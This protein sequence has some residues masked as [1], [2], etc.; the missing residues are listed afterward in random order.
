MFPFLFFACWSF[1]WY[2]QWL[3]KIMTGFNAVWSNHQTPQLQ[4][5]AERHVSELSFS[6][7]QLFCHTDCEILHQLIFV[8]ISQHFQHIFFCCKFKLGREWKT[9]ISMKYFNVFQ[10]SISIFCFI[11][12][13]LSLNQ[14]SMTDGWCKWYGCF[15][16]FALDSKLLFCLGTNLPK[17]EVKPNGAKAD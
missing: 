9:T 5:P 13:L 3:S 10:I 7:E 6:G 1:H 17:I 4:Y 2:L 11:Q 15:F 16:M 14:A 12:C 8:G